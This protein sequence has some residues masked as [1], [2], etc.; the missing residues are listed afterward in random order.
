E[1]VERSPT[2]GGAC[3]PQVLDRPLRMLR[4]D[5][6]RLVDPTTH[7]VEVELT[8]AQLEAVRRA[9]AHETVRRRAEVASQARDVAVQG[10]AP[11][12]GPVAGW[13]ERLVEGVHR[14]GA[15]LC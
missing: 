10:A 13:P 2:P 5:G 3:L 6:S 14:H 11:G 1:L 7:L 9:L 15:P 4:Q 12:V 8:G